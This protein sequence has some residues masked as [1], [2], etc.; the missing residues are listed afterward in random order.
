MSERLADQQCNGVSYTLTT[1][2]ADYGDVVAV[3]DVSWTD[4]DLSHTLNSSNSTQTGRAVAINGVYCCRDVGD[5]CNR[6][7]V[8]TSENCQTQFNLSEASA[9]CTIGTPTV[10]NDH[11]DCSIVAT[12]E[13][14]A[15]EKTVD[16]LKMDD[17]HYCP[18]G[19]D[20]AGYL[21]LDPNC[22]E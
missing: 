14:Q 17:L 8:V 6:S 13:G 4:D 2:C 21:Q 22:A 10:E 11:K 16:Y 5:L 20:R 15:Y 12:C 7:D 3:V 19:D 1:E 18:G 9:F